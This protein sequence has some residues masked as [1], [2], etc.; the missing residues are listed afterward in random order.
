M[1]SLMQINLQ[2]QASVYI[3]SI[4]FPYTIHFDFLRDRSP[5][6]T[7]SLAKDTNLFHKLFG[8][9]TR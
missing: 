2:V 5:A 7:S 3:S 9:T 6:K 8:L 4:V 1:R